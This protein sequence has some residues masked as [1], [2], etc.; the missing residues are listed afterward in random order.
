MLART[1]SRHIGRSIVPRSA[2]PATSVYSRGFASEDTLSIPTDREQQA[3]RRKNE[4]D[5]EEKGVTIYNRDP[6]VPKSDQG[7]KENPILVRKIPQTK[8]NL[9]FIILMMNRGTRQSR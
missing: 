3:G 9:F 7:T 8:P 4:L 1:F 5:A 2:A 6:I